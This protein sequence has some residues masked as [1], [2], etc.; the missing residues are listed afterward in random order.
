MPAGSIT[1]QVLEVDAVPSSAEGKLD[2]GMLLALAQHPVR[3][4]V[5]QQQ[6][7]VSLEDAGADGLFDLE[8]GAVVDDHRVDPAEAKQ[9]G[10]HQPGGPST[11][12]TDG[13]VGDVPL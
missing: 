1:D 3:H 6:Y 12:D 8:P 2:P 9:V 7:A 11:D 4:G 10:E 5:D 13:G